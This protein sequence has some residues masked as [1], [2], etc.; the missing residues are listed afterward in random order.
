M[1]FENPTDSDEN[2]KSVVESSLIKS[3]N[4]NKFDIYFYNLR[5]TDIYGPYLLDLKE[6]LSREHIERYNSKIISDT[7]FYNGQLVGLVLDSFT[8]NLNYN[9][10]K[11]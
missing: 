10:L 1:N 3:I 7:C 8:N 11:K 6:L 4:N 2:Y 9:Q 5:F